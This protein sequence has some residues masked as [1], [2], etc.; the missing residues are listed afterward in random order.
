MRKCK[1]ICLAL[2]LLISVRYLSNASWLVPQL[3]DGREILAHRG[4]HQIFDPIGV[5]DKTCTASRIDTP[6]H[7][8]IENTLPSIRAAID[9]GA[10]IIEF[11]V[12]PTTDGE[13]VVF[14]DWGLE[15]RTNGTGVVREQSSR[16]LKSLDIGYGY[17]SDG[18]KTYPFRGKYIGAMPKLGEV[19][20]EF[21]EN[22]FM[23]NIKSR[24]ITEA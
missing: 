4:I 17:T 7:N 5:T 6:I 12:H 24:N 16:Y 2:L 22:K 10:D 9:L 23:I 14:H 20:S 18:G 13:F 11:D 15:C 21:P 8:Y 1:T 19:L 3:N